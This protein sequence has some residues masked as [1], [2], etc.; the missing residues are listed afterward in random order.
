[1]T[2]V[3]V[4]V[5]QGAALRA[6]LPELAGLRIE[7]FRDFPYLYEGS[8]DYEE[9][10]LATY[11]EAAGSV[12]VGAFDGGRLVGAATALPLAEETDETRRPF[13]DRGMDLARIF[14]FGESVLLR[15]WR[16]RGIGHAFFEHR[17]AAARAGGFTHACFCAV[18][19]PADHPLRP[20]G[21]VPLD[22][23]WR[24]RGYAP[25]PDLT[26]G[27]TWRDL[28]EEHETGKPMQ[29]WMR[30]LAR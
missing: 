18:V 2:D 23:F 9:R 16:G 20:P 29:F 15:P 28:G 4:E 11:A 8:R 22:G 7:V 12:I 6:R 10:Y 24:R 30:E 27:F 5:L 14:Y 17:E 21:Y 19:R 1:M 3:R 26:A 13:L 25:V